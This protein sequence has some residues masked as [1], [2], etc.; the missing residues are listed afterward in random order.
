MHRSIPR[1]QLISRCRSWKI[2]IS[3]IYDIFFFSRWEDGISYSSEVLIARYLKCCINFLE[4]KL[5]SLYACHVTSHMYWQEFHVVTH[6]IKYKLLLEYVDEIEFLA[7]FWWN[8]IFAYFLFYN[9]RHI[10]REIESCNPMR[11]QNWYHNDIYLTKIT[12][13]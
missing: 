11:V 8:C 6:N 4:I 1:K 12:W 13:S 7:Q 3:W 2:K 9:T 5:W 10:V